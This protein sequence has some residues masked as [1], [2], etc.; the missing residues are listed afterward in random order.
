MLCARRPRAVLERS[1]RCT[2][3]TRGSASG[4]D[5]AGRDIHGCPIRGCRI[6]GTRPAFLR[7]GWLA[8]RPGLSRAL[9]RRSATCTGRAVIGPG[10]A[11]AATA[12]ARLGWRGDQLTSKHLNFA[13]GFNADL[14]GVAS[15]AQYLDRDVV[16]DLDPFLGLSRQYQHDLLLLSAAAIRRPEVRIVFLRPP[17]GRAPNAREKVKRLLEKRR[18]TRAMRQTSCR[19]PDVRSCTKRAERSGIRADRS[20]LHGDKNLTRAAF[21]STLPGH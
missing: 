20:K 4:T 3:P 9:I 12:V 13:G 19:L 7:G 10:A 16:T 21:R 15:H 8:V 6:C 1:Q 11:I 5:R 14:H 2:S 18:A 17:R